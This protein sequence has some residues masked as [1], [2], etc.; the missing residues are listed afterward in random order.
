[1]TATATVTVPTVHLGRI[2]WWHYNAACGSGGADPEIFFPPATGGTRAA[3]EA[4]TWCNNC[5][6]VTECLD[7]AV[8]TR[9][10]GIWGGTTEEQRALIRRRQHRRA[11]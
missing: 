8:R 6:V 7:Y 11:H 1:M 10:Q 9:Q 3:A 2:P 5:P 4:R